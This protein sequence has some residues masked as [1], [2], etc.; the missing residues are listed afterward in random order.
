MVCV[1]F[2]LSGVLHAQQE[3]QFTNTALNPYYLN[4]AAGGITDVMQFELN[5]RTQWL[6][7]NGGPRTMMFSAHSQ[8]RK[9]KGEKALSEF[10]VKDEPF[11]ELPKASTGKIKHCVGGKMINDAIG[12]FSKSGVSASYAIHLPLVGKTNFG[13]GI[14]LGW[15]NFRIDEKRVVLHQTEDPSYDQFLGNTSSMNFA[16]VQAGLV[17]YDEDYFLGISTTQLLNNTVRFNE[18]ETQSNF[19]RHYFIVGRYTI[20]LSDRLDLEPLAVA[21][22]VNNSPWSFDLGARFLFNKSSWIA[23]QYR[24]SN[25]LCFQLGSTLVKNLYLSYAYEHAVG[26]ISQ[27]GIGSHE[28]QL[29][30]WIGNNRNL[31]KE[32]KATRSEEEKSN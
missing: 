13:A 6:G 21:K 15:S 4:P 16:D 2:A 30:L 19:N 9:K 10:N 18:T 22:Y 32:I 23:L 24:T 14:G 7:Y 17:F 27:G 28:I 8:I 12:P 1:V 5:G 29:G 26:K 20:P 31:D 11:F 3:F 25:A